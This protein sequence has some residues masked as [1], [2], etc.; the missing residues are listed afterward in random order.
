M[1]GIRFLDEL[2]APQRSIMLPFQLQSAQRWASLQ[3]ETTLADHTVAMAVDAPQLEL[4]SHVAANLQ[5][6]IEHTK[7]IYRQAEGEATKVMPT[8]AGRSWLWLRRSS[9]SPLP[10]PFSPSSNTLRPLVARSCV[11]PQSFSVPLSPTASTISGPLA[12][13]SFQQ[14]RMGMMAFQLLS[15]GTGTHA[16]ISYEPAQF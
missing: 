12:T 1:T 6:R 9:I 10:R 4:Y 7:E 3:S 11:A 15:E 16:C 8:A 2:S 14:M 13:F 5:R